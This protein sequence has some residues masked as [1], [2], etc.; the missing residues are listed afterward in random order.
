MN[1]IIPILCLW[2]M[3]LFK[4]IIKY[5]SAPELLNEKLRTLHSVWTNFFV[6]PLPNSGPHLSP[7]SCKVEK[8]VG[9]VFLCRLF[10]V[11]YKRPP[12]LACLWCIILDLQW[13]CKSSNQ[14][15]DFCTPEIRRKIRKTCLKKEGLKEQRMCLCVPG[16]DFGLRLYMLHVHTPGNPRGTGQII[17]H[18][19]SVQPLSPSFLHTR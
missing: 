17:S 6:S 4:K 3:S 11:T 14:G 8:T 9:I 5:S 2:R 16:E 10:M 15:G 1:F 7:T 18:V 12:V 19:I 13:D